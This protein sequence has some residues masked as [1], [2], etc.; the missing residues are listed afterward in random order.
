MG[1]LYCYDSTEYVKDMGTP[2]RLS[3]VES[4][5]RSGLVQSRSRHRLRRA[6]FLDRDGVL[7][8]YVGYVRKPEDLELL[9]GVAE[10]IHRI[11]TSGYL[12]IVVTNQPVVARGEVTWDQLAEINAKLETL[13]GLEGAYVD[14][15]YVCP[16][17]P[18]KGFAGEDPNLKIECD[19]RKPKP[20]MLIA[21]AEKYNL[22]LNEC[23][24]VGDSERDVMAGKSAGT[25]TAHLQGQG[26][27]AA[28]G[29][30]GQN[31]THDTLLDFVNKRG[32]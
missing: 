19:C 28:N 3:Q 11:N 14:A 13:L 8:R 23:W 27:C 17:H 29:D 22:N 16:H 7:N 31:E 30:Y 5:I 25:M 26:T 24:M 9:P 6:V 4:D 20:G 15:I 21:A 1:K 10:A 18:D 2:E 12:A 32:W